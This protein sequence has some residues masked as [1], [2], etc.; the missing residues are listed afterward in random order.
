MVSRA[1]AT[2]NSATTAP[3]IR[4]RCGRR[5]GQ[6]TASRSDVENWRC[7][8]DGDGDEDKMAIPSAGIHDL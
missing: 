5:Y 6:N 1:P 2:I 4:A 3:A 7:G 8:D